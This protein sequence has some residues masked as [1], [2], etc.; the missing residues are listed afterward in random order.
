MTRL[1]VLALNPS[2]D[3]EWRVP[4]VQWEEKN[5]ILSQRRWA[6][7]KGINVARWIKHLGVRPQLIVPLG[8]A[9]GR[10]M[11]EWLQAERFAMKVIPIAEE[12]RTNYIVSV[13]RGGQL[14]FNPTGPRLS[15]NEWANIYQVTDAELRETD[16]LILSGSLP[17]GLSAATYRSLVRRAHYRGVKTVLD[18]DGA[19]L[20]SA[21]LSKPFLI[22]P[23]LPELAHWH[24]R[25][26][27]SEGEIREAALAMSRVTQNWILVSLGEKGGLLVNAHEN[28][29][30]WA[31]PPKIEVENTV[32][33]GDAL[34]AAVA[35]RIAD[36]A[37]HSEWLRCGVG[38]GASAAECGPGAVP[39]KSGLLYALSRVVLR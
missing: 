36:R 5:Q 22:K 33:A 28:A 11:E 3:V 2:I 26:L 37:P 1:L 13:A 8:G 25:T 17:C 24:Q 30:L 15:R 39:A 34:V 19:A 14:R 4:E 6:G 12:T 32:G 20:A 27:H 10:E 38:A 21:V 9:S 35:I 23:N 18:C 31:S 16:L 29:E 7:G